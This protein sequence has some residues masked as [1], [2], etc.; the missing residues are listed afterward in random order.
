MAPWLTDTFEALL[1]PMDI[2]IWLEPFGGGAG[3]A[4]T[5][6]GTGRVPEAWIV[7][8]NP[9][10]AA[11]WTT[12]MTDGPALAAR[13]EATV[14]TLAMFQDARETVAAALAG[15]QLEPFELGF[16]AFLLNRC[17]RSGMIL[18]SVGP[19]GGKAQAGLHTIGARFNA[20]AL[21]ERIR[22]VHALG[23]RFKVFAGDGIS[24]LEELPDSGIGDEVFCFVDPPY[25]GVGND[26]YA[27][28]MDGDLHQ[29]LALALNQLHT[30]WLLTYDAH[31][32]IPQLYPGS[33][34]VEFDIPHTAG[35][36]RVGTEYLVLGPG[37]ALP[38][39]NPLG[40]GAIQR[41]AA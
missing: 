17:S 16:S 28:G 4:L 7:E 14:P 39:A 37:M 11:F 19:I 34:V 41:L 32:R 33:D 31:P 12:V 9:A 13:I 6:L 5:A 21:A 3:A 26:L 24:F 25:I 1:G 35:A 38:A 29:R 40:K 2:E 27:V 22:G 20:P 36:S 23:E 18:P 8:A 30:P 15:E 10:L